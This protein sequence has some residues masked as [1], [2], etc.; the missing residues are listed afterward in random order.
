MRAEEMR[1]I[2]RDLDRL[3]RNLS[4]EELYALMKMEDI[5]RHYEE[6]KRELGQWFWVLQGCE[7]FRRFLSAFNGTGRC[8]RFQC[9]SG[10]Q[11]LFSW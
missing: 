4:A 8:H 2:L 10:G 9:K 5:E 3:L 11:F 7:D 6:I 1:R